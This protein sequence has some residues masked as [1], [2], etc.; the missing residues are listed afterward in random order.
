[1]WVKKNMESM[2]ALKFI[3]VELLAF[4]MLDS[5]IGVGNMYVN[6]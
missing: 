2:M 4:G 6:K 5:V 1:L 3:S